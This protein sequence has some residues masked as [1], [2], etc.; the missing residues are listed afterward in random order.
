M[1]RNFVCIVCPLG[2]P[3]VAEE[4]T[5]GIKVTGNTCKRGEVYAIKECTNPE[6]T[7]TTTVRC[8]GGEMLSV[9]TAKPIPKEKMQEA[10]KIIN[11]CHPDLPISIGDVIIEDVYGSPVV[12]TGRKE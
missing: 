3:L 12:A 1:K 4:T 9:K 11:S 5:E 8:R 2:C 7:L 6:R 10:M